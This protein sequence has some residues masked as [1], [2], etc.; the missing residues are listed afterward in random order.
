M[1][2]V[3]VGVVLQCAL[4]A[5]GAQTYEKALKQ[6]EGNG[7]PL[8]VLVGTEWCPGC[9]TMK[10]QVLARMTSG[11]KLRK[12]N[13]AT[14]DADDETD[15][16]SQLMRGNAIPQ[17]IVFSQ[18]ADGVWHREQITG[19]AT[20]SQV[21]ALIGRALAAQQAKTASSQPRSVSGN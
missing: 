3:S 11:G 9:H 5:S 13:Y 4:I 6:A 12:V 15:L 10:D 16:A 14:V 21:A 18:R 19:T 8:L 1:V 2:G 7:Q 17:L 20:E